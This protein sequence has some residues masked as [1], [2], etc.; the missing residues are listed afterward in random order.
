MRTSHSDLPFGQTDQLAALE[1][2]RTNSLSQVHGIK[3][4]ELQETSD[5]LYSST[6]SS[7]STTVKPVQNS[8]VKPSYNTTAPSSTKPANQ[9]SKPKPK[10]LPRGG[11]IDKPKDLVDN[12]K[13]LVD[14]S[15]RSV[16][17][18]V[19]K[20]PSTITPQKSVQ[21]QSTKNQST[22]NPKMEYVE[23]NSSKPVNNATAGLKTLPTKLSDRQS[24]GI[25]R[26]IIYND[27]AAK[28]K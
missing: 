13:D 17:N 16:S 6:R 24:V 8:T 3:D 7:A 10:P 27:R 21:N 20:N 12:S 4:E 28:R 22:K 11:S 26:Y 18:E 5:Q 1:K 23:P 14:K 19:K 9:T 15:K 25:F 2:R